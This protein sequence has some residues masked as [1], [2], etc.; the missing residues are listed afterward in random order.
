M[1]RLPFY[2]VR[3]PYVGEGYQ[4]H[5]RETE[6]RIFSQDVIEELIVLAV[7][8]S[9]VQAGVSDSFLVH[10]TLSNTNSPV[11]AKSRISQIYEFDPFGVSIKLYHKI[12]SD[13]NWDIEDTV[14]TVHF[15]PP[16]Q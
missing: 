1:R 5:I 9:Q 4:Y 2:L 6:D 7:K 3:A 14:I 8:L 15:F 13:S 12:M 11:V 16:G 10:V